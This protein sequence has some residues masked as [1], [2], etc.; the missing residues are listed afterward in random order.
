M[1]KVGLTGGIGSGKSLVACVLKRLGVPVYD[2]DL[3]TKRLYVTNPELKRQLIENF[4]PETYF[5][6]GQLN[7]KFLGEIIFGDK[8]KLGLINK[9]VH[10]IVR[11]DFEEWIK[12]NDKRNYI[13]KEAAILIESGAYKQVDK[14]IVVNSPLKLRIKRVIV[15]DN[16]TQEEVLKRMKS[17]LSGEQLLTY[18]DYI[19]KNDNENLLLPQ[20]LTIHKQLQK[21]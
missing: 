12:K 14:I 9:I 3:E 17:Q 1:I 13:I 11:L 7:R 21:L 15:R 19:V 18:A 4:G 20:I 2:S 16:T 10:P 8:S 5:K 6:N